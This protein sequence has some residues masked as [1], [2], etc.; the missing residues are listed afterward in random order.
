[1]FGNRQ[2]RGCGESPPLRAAFTQ[3]RTPA[4][5]TRSGNSAGVRR[6][7]AHGQL[8]EGPEHRLARRMTGERELFDLLD[9]LEAEAQG[10]HHAERAEEVADRGRAEYAE[11]TLASRLM[12]SVG[13]HVVLDVAGVGGLPGRLERVGTGWARISGAR[14]EW[15]VRTE[16][17]VH[18]RGASSRSLPEVAW[19]PV[20][21]LGL[22]AALR[23]LAEAEAEVVV[24]GLDGSRREGR[25]GRV[26]AD[27]VEVA[28]PG[29]QVGLVTLAHVAAVRAV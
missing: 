14:G 23:R 11:V 15:L 2:I 1:M 28:A 21:R 5:Y 7:A 17:V 10:L 19:S 26:G 29:G 27:F 13:S 8:R 22:G 25:V 4:P 12:A 20:D 24:H 18:V 9:D 6:R 16:A 3:P